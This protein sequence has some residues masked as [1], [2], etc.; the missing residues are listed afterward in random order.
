MDEIYF[1]KLGKTININKIIETLNLFPTDIA[2]VS[3][4]LVEEI[5]NTNSKGMGNRLSDIDIFIIREKEYFF[6]NTIIDGSGYDYNTLKVTFNKYMGISVDIECYYIGDLLNTIKQLNKID[7]INCEKNKRVRNWII[8]PHGVLLRNFMSF[9]HRLYYSIPLYN[10]EK[11]FNFKNNINYTNYFKYMSLLKILEMDNRY[12]DVLGN[13]EAKEYFVAL[14]E[15]REMLN[16]AVASY[17]YYKKESIDR[18]KWIPLRLKNVSLLDKDSK[19]IYDEYSKLMFNSPLCKE[20][21][22]EK[23]IEDIMNLSEFIVAYI[24]NK[25]KEK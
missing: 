19:Y 12:S 18:R 6:E 21:Q 24:Q 22:Y 20:Q 10:H 14:L 25:D 11:Y 8:P 17:L 9:L 3:G 16:D 1:K 7:F 4:S 13:L 5:T 23:N 2:F 15:G